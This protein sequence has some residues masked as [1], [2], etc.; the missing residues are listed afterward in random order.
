[1]TAAPDVPVVLFLF[2]RPETLGRVVDV[3]R[4]V[5]PPL[6]FTIADGPRPDR[7]EDAARCRAARAI[8]EQ[9]DWPC[10]V[11]RNYADTNMGCT[12]R[13][14]SGLNWAFQEVAEAIVLED[15]VIPDPTF[16]A[17]CTRMLDR[18]R[19]EPNVMHVSGRNHLGRWTET[20]AGHC[21]LR[22]AS[23]S[24]WATWRRAWRHKVPMPGTPDDI[25]RIATNS[26]IEPLVA[27]NFLMLQELAVIGKFQSWDTTWELKKALAGGLSVVP[28]V[29]LVANIGFGPEATHTKFE[30]DL[31]AL[32]PVG[33][34]PSGT[35][36]DRCVEDQ[37]LD[38]WSILFELMA[39]YRQ[40]AVAWRLAR[41]A[42]LATAKFWSVDRRLSHHL[43]PLR[44]ARESLAAL[45]HFCASGGAAEPLNDLF[46]ALRRAAADEPVAVASA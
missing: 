24:G 32:T 39:T 34:A 12:A 16:F 27:D 15:D 25:A 11:V 6:I 13:I 1:M 5:Q 10:R 20:G 4:R 45:E 23:V 33:V 9:F 26:A 21:L 8:V 22:R 29:N 14:T 30:G 46:C 36:A 18:Y 41:S 2:N 17:W 28:S 43:A 35:E 40:P 38:L 7:P 37:R 19:D 42:H 44:N 31:R 3:L